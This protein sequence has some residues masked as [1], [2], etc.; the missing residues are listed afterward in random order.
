MKFNMK[1]LP[2]STDITLRVVVTSDNS[3]YKDGLGYPRN[4]TGLK[5]VSMGITKPYTKYLPL[6][7]ADDV[8]GNLS[9]DYMPHGQKD[10]LGN[11]LLDLTLHVYIDG[12][13]NFSLKDDVDASYYDRIAPVTIPR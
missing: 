6:V 2:N 9:L 5:V 10:D 8:T 11:A 1:Q 12:T 7:K 3:Q 4:I 13:E